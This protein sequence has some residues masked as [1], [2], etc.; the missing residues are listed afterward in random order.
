MK[1]AA[2]VKS[3]AYGHGLVE[4]SKTLVK[5][6]ADYLAA[7]AFEEATRIR[8]AGV[9]VPLLI[10]NQPVPSQAEFCVR[11]NLTPFVG[12]LEI[13]KIL[14]AEATK[15]GKILSVH[16][17]VDTGMGRFGVLPEDALSLAESITEMK[18][19]HLEGICTHFANAQGK[20]QSQTETQFTKFQ[21]VLDQLS[22]H[23]IK[24]P[25]RHAANSAALLNFPKMRLDMVRPGT[26]LYGQYPSR[27]VKK[28]LTLKPTWQFKTKICLIKNLPQ[29]WAVGY[30]SE[31]RTQRKTRLGILPIGYA[32]G[33]SVEPASALRGLRGIRNAFL[34]LTGHYHLKVQIKGHYVPIIGRI[35]AQ[36]CCV[37]LTE[38]PDDIRVGEEVILPAR[39]VL[40]SPDV[41]RIYIP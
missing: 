12:S 17:K 34:K 35:A 10:M 36:S 13:A 8:E 28:D 23:N 2:V 1:I 24:I 6:G 11:M 4:I 20:D 14:S 21:G 22:S 25:L 29:G 9:T 3:S 26:I 41:P 15:A 7:S 33:L 39:R 30:G 16:L 40:T 38:L 32:Q 5:T 18:G 37:D 31:F 27:W 19:L